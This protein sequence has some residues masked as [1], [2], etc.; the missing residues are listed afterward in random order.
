MDTRLTAWQF[1]LNP[2]PFTGSIV[3]LKLIRVNWFA[4]IVSGLA[5]GSSADKKVVVNRLVYGWYSSTRDNYLA[6]FH[7]FAKFC[8]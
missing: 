6:A 3:S 7:R 8:S 4:S 1:F 2:P 5:V